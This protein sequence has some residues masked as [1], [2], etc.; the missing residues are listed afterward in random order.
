MKVSNLDIPVKIDES[1]L[2]K[3]FPHKASDIKVRDP[4]ILLCDGWYFFI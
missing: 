4:F 3:N 1:I 2:P